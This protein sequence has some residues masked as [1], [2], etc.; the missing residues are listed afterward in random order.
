MNESPI[1]QATLYTF[2]GKEGHPVKVVRLTERNPDDWHT[3]PDKYLHEHTD[4]GELLEI[5]GIEFV[6]DRLLISPA[7]GD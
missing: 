6:D 4:I 7:S 2:S 1:Q 3:F 5:S